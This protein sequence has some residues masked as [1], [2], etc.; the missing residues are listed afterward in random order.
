[1]RSFALAALL[2]VVVSLAIHLTRAIDLDL[3]VPVLPQGC[4]CVAVA[5]HGLPIGE[6]EPV[7]RHCLPCPLRRSRS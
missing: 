1:M 3:T 4:A 2:V 7:S 6:Q 5:D